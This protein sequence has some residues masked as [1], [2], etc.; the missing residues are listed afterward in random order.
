M[1]FELTKLCKTVWIWVRI[2]VTTFFFIS[3]ICM[4]FSDESST[5]MNEDPSP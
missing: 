3:T 4:K 1:N 2:I 5:T